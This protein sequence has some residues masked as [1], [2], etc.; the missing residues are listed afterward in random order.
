[1]NLPKVIARG[2][3]PSWL[4]RLRSVYRAGLFHL[5]ISIIFVQ[6]LTY[7]SQLIIANMVGPAKFGIVRNVEA[8]ISI[9]VLFGSAGMPTL[10]VK[11][12]AQTID[13]VMRGRIL[14][15]LIRL[16]FAISLG[17]SIFVVIAAPR[18]VNS[19]VAKYLTMLVW[20]VA[21]ISCSRTC[22]N[23]F[24]GIKQI[25]QSSIYTA[26][27]SVVSLILVTLSVRFAGLDGWIVARYISEGLFVALTLFLT[28]KVVK[29]T[30][31]LP[32]AY[33]YKA[34]M[35]LGGPIAG[36]LF[37]RSTLDNAGVLF[38]G[39]LGATNE[40]V[41]Y[42]SLGAILVI[43]LMIL[44]AGLSNLA[45]PRLAERSSEPAKLLHF[46]LNLITQTLI[47]VVSLSLIGVFIVPYVIQIFLP[48]YIPGIATIQILMLV[49]PFRA[50]A[51]MCGAVLT[52]LDKNKIIMAG[53][54]LL[55]V[56]AVLIYS[57]TI[58][59][60]GSIGAAWGTVGIEIISVIMFLLISIRQVKKRI[61]SVD[62]R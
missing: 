7:V 24:Q 39:R 58:A 40:E 3:V 4:A 5:I 21:L 9:V 48:E 25:H 62:I 13:P 27:L 12:I 36:S 14:G 41:G 15:R 38:L 33:S 23:Y 42:Y 20:V 51:S 50:I 10:A 45:M 1:M 34:L 18:F 37:L 53:H 16:A 26:V 47:L 19:D 46:F 56:I 55:L 61:A 57:Y 29:F 30:G 60:F 17:I 28:R 49:I 43:V 8:I 35:L 11:S 2:I 54:G 52:A 32:E 31:L 44:P 6:G 59:R 22:I